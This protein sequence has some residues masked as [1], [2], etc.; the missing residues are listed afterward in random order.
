MSRKSLMDESSLKALG[1]AEW[2]RGRYIHGPT[3][4]TRPV[5]GDSEAG[6]YFLLQWDWG[7][8]QTP[9]SV[10]V[11][12]CYRAFASSIGETLV[13]SVAAPIGSGCCCGKAHRSPECAAPSKFCAQQSPSLLRAQWDR[14]VVNCDWMF[15]TAH[16][17]GIGL[18]GPWRMLLQGFKS[19]HVELGR[20]D[21]E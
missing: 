16:A 14:V 13:A 8:E 20:C 17:R 3:K 21:Y 12:Y 19:L 15:A 11:S 6:P 10:A 9:Y 18:G 2:G 7:K 1:G 4:A 5:R